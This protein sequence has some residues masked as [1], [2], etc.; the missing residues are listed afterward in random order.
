[1]H[2]KPL[3]LIPAIMMI[4]ATSSFA[5]VNAHFDVEQLHPEQCDDNE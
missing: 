3:L 2:T 1:M 5:N 4:A